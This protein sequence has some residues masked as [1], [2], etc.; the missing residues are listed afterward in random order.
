MYIDR[1]YYP[2]ETLGYGKRLGVWTIG[3]PHHCKNCSN[4]ELQDINSNKSIKVNDVIKII[5]QFKYKIDGITITG[6][7]P[8]YQYNDLLDLLIKINSIELFDVLVYTGYTM[9]EIIKLNYTEALKYIG[10]LIDG[11]YEVEFDNGVGM[12]GSQNQKVYILK[13]ELS[14]RY[15]NFKQ[16]KRKSQLV[17]YNGELWSIGIPIKIN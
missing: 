5:Q 12:A 4:P 2:V 15:A 1:I 14:I 8:F 13:D 6:G 10:V 7:D 17:N 9:E 3:C 11:R 16:E